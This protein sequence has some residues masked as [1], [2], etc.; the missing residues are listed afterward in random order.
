MKKTG[1]Q[2]ALEMAY[3]LGNGA[4]TL[5]LISRYSSASKLDET[6]LTENFKKHIGISLLEYIDR[7]KNSTNPIEDAEEEAKHIKVMIDN[8]ITDKKL[9]SATLLYK[10]FEKD[11]GTGD[12]LESF[13][14]TFKT[15]MEKFGFD[16]DLTELQNYLLRLGIHY[17]LRTMSF[18]QASESIMKTINN[19]KKLLKE[20]NRLVTT[21]S[22]RKLKEFLTN[23]AIQ[24]FDLE[25]DIA[26]GAS[27]QIVSQMI[28][29]PQVMPQISS[30]GAYTD[31][32]IT[33]QVDQQ[34]E[35]E[36][37]IDIQA[38]E[39]QSDAQLT[40]EPKN[41]SELHKLFLLLMTHYGE[42]SD[43]LKDMWY[44][45]C[46]NL[47]SQG[48]WSPA[49]ER[50]EC[51]L[52]CE[53]A[54][55]LVGGLSEI[56]MEEIKKVNKPLPK[57]D[58]IDAAKFIYEWMKDQSKKVKSPL[59]ESNLSNEQETK[60]WSIRLNAIKEWEAKLG[61]KSVDKAW[62]AFLKLDETFIADIKS[63]IADAKNKRDISKLKQLRSKLSAA[64][65]YG[66]IIDNIDDTIANFK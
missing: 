49:S 31:Q 33:P 5:K 59:V 20:T 27:Q 55:M 44:G 16:I 2:I 21:N 8:G 37:E 45:T 34:I 51:Q 38:V 52:A 19:D 54:K 43:A 30:T 11:H 9:P 53:D 28:P 39:I 18:Q 61:T 3:Q 26:D 24:G 41:L 60:Y 47:Q 4:E 17:N 57:K 65:D 22:K 40:D 42:M 15:I 66:S 32:A 25:P 50:Y 35:P 58:T 23:L 12:L 14:M 10:W 6:R 63:K 46:E 62:K 48:N 13:V 56:V 7:F 29:E 64:G 1:K 36:P